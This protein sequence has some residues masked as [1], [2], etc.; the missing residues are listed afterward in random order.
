MT[1]PR[2]YLIPDVCERLR[3]PQS[4]FYALRA[5]GRL[6]FLQE[7]RP[8]AGRRVRYRADLVDQYLEGRHGLEMLRRPRVARH[9]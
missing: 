5:K 3:I 7:I 6:P 9:A 2:V 8:R 4:S 1:E